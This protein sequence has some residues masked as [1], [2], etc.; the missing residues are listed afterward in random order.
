MRRLRKQPKLTSSRVVALPPELLPCVVPLRLSAAWRIKSALV[1]LSEVRRCLAALDSQPTLLSSGTEVGPDWEA[2]GVD[3]P[4]RVSFER[5]MNHF[6]FFRSESNATANLADSAGAEWLN[7]FC[8]ALSN[9]DDP[10]P[11]R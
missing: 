1:L 4:F 10:L 3:T 7:G 8:I 11:R 6:F 9:E 2:H 5:R